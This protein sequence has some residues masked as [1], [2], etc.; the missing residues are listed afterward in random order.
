MKRSTFLAPVLGAVL[1]LPLL[2]NAQVRPDNPTRSSDATRANDSG[3]AAPRSYIPG[4]SYGYAGINLGRS[5]YGDV[6]CVAGFACDDHPDLAGK[7]YTGGLVSGIF[8]VELGYLNLGAA[9]RNGGEVQAQGVNVSLVA[10]L[11]IDKF[12]AFAKVGTSYL[13]NE[14][15]A[16]PG[17]GVLTGEE[18]GF[19][20]SYGA[21]LGFDI[22]PNMQVIAEWDRNRVEFVSGKRNID[23]LS[24]GFR[25]KF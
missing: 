8:G 21:G 3:R 9:D 12:N 18:D 4:T 6:P 7:I 25:W 2:A 17:T 20:L 11:P 13:W 5:D 22:N 14:I 15:T 16:A 1:A 23:M 24:V 10:N 19:G